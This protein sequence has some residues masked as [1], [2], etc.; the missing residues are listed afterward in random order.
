MEGVAERL[1]TRK[2]E[3]GGNCSA[4]IRSHRQQEKQG[5]PARR[6]REVKRS[7]R[8]PDCP[9]HLS[10][11]SDLHRLPEQQGPEASVSMDETAENSTNRWD[12]CRY[13]KP[14]RVP[15]RIVMCWRIYIWRAFLFQTRTFSAWTTPCHSL[16]TQSLH[17][18]QSHLSHVSTSALEREKRA[19][20]LHL[21]VMFKLQV[22]QGLDAEVIRS[23]VCRAIGRGIFVGWYDS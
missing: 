11:P 23:V 22:K 21:L 16:R 6:R 20:H 3:E 12:R 15:I 1:R 10:G 17:T 5:K 7:Q 19:G 9:D 4:T 14:L 2:V 18:S 8:K 13:P